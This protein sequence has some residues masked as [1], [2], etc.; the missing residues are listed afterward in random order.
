ME[1]K[2]KFKGK[3]LNYEDNFK[4]SVGKT[5]IL[6]KAFKCLVLL[7]KISFSCENTLAVNKL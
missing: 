2:I 4:E 5:K 1:E 6:R 3:R 7:K